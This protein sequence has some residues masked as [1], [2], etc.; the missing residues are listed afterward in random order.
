MDRP[1]E[2][3]VRSDQSIDWDDIEAHHRPVTLISRPAYEVR[4]LSL[5]GAILVARIGLLDWA[6]YSSV[7]RRG[8]T[9]S[10]VSAPRAA[11]TP[12]RRRR[13]VLERE[14]RQPMA[15]VHTLPL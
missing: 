1:S 12:E 5:L 8:R 11:G 6:G 14:F 4:V 7:H 2:S 9:P 10:G 3:A 13:T 15:A